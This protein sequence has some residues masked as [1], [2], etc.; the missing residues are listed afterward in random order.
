M[1][2]TMD[3]GVKGEESSMRKMASADKEE[4]EKRLTPAQGRSISENQ[5]NL[6]RY[7]E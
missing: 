6:T 4:E 1:K 3:E 7:K 2:N 5:F